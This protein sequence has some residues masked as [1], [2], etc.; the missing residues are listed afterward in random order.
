MRKNYIITYLMGMSIPSD[1]VCRGKKVL[2]LGW[3]TCSSTE[4]DEM[5][6]TK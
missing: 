6:Q 1:W 2:T 5:L 3:I 4:T